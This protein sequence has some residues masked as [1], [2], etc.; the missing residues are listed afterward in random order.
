MHHIVL[1]WWKSHRSFVHTGTW[2]STVH[3]SVEREQLQVFLKLLLSTL[4]CTW[5]WR[6]IKQGDLEHFLEI[7]G[8]GT[9]GVKWLINNCLH[10]LKILIVLIYLTETFENYSKESKIRKI[11]PKLWSEEII[12][13]TLVYFSNF[14][15]SITFDSL[16]IIVH[17]P[18]YIIWM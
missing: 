3:L 4:H 13:E 7:L 17:V 9:M 10:F 5:L 8:R 11:I 2:I 14:S 6:V 1:K 18:F 12:P 15:T 16:K